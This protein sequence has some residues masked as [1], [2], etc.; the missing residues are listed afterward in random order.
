MFCLICKCFFK[1]ECELVGAGCASAAAVG[2]FDACDNVFCLHA[3]DELSDALGVTVATADEFN[4][5]DHAVCDLHVDLTGASAFGFVF[6]VFGHGLYRY[7]FEEY[8][9]EV[10]ELRLEDGARRI[11][12]NT[13]GKN[14]EG[15][16][17]EFLDFMDYINST[18]DEVAKRSN[19]PRIKK[20][21]NR[22]CSVK[23]SE[24][25]GVK[26]MQAWEE[27]YYEKLESREEGLAE[28]R[29]KGR[30]EV[31]NEIIGN[32]LKMKM[33]IETIAKCVG[34]T[35]EEIE[36]MADRLK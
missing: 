25:V 8:C 29:V 35:I 31:C 3:F 33:P 16:S 9:K 24:K 23:K 26:L 14:A 22:V 12:I 32:M 27:L 20:I 10:P 19:S 1:S 7:T 13:K 34:K 11:F 5:I 6:D 17:K 2:A 36:T 21:H 30:N 18:T 4:G 15:F 28:G